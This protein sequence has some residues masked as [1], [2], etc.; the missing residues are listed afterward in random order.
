[1]GQSGARRYGALDIKIHE[2]ISGAVSNISDKNPYVVVEWAAEDAQRPVA[3]VGRRGLFIPRQFQAAFVISHLHVVLTLE[4]TE[5]L[6]EIFELAGHEP[7]AM[8]GDA[9]VKR[10]EVRT[11]RFWL[12]RADEFSRIPLSRWT[13]MAVAAAAGTQDEIKRALPAEG[14]TERELRQKRVAFSDL[15]PRPVGRPRTE[16]GLTYRGRFIALAEVRSVAAAGGRKHVKAV[17]KHFGDP[18]YPVPRTTARRWIARA[19]AEE[20]GD[21]RPANTGEASADSGSLKVE[22][23][24]ARSSDFRS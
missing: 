14:A 15:A 17:Q 20:R 6:R 21:P 12:I 3:I 4:A 13:T 1:L 16:T 18:G 24:G 7:P 10:V 8:Q 22:N 9:M 23:H 2:L 11:D 19:L 5:S